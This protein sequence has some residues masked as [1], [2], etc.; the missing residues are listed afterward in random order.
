MR[1]AWAVIVV[2][3]V[4]GGWLSAQFNLVGAQSAMQASQVYDGASMTFL[5]IIALTLAFWFVAAGETPAPRSPR[6][7]EEPIMAFKRSPLVEPKPKQ[8]LGQ[9]GQVFAPLP[10]EEAT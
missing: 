8:D 4:G 10:D 5:A 9:I 1:I 2:L 7:Q 6:P 3:V